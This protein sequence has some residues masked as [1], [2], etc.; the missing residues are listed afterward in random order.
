MAK[1]STG[2]SEQRKPKNSYQQRWANQYSQAW[3]D[4]AIERLADEMLVW[5]QKEENLWLK[6]FCV[7]KMVHFQRFAEWANRNGYFAFILSACKI[8]QESK[9]VKLGLSK[10][11]NVSMPI[12][13]LKNVAGW[14]DVRELTGP[15][16][17]PLIP[18]KDPYE[19]LAEICLNL[20]V[21]LPGGDG[22]Q[23]QGLLR[24]K[25]ER[26]LNFLIP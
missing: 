10:N 24:E 25:I 11:F 16:G 19:E 2:K 9:L 23:D 14:R 1:R 22:D 13:A 4:S 6:D 12:F 20:S 15:E 26:H 21:T 18:S 5:F 17:Q 8:I 7:E 3:T